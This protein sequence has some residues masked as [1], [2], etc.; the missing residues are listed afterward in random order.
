[1]R[2][3]HVKH[4]DIAMAP[5]A[6]A[7]CQ[8][9]YGIKAAVNDYDM[10]YDIVHFHDKYSEVDFP[11]VIQYHSEPGY[12]V[13]LNVK[14]PKLVINQYHATLLNYYDCNIVQNIIDMDSDVFRDTKVGGIR[15]GY[16]PSS[17]SK[18]SE[19]AN[20]G[21]N[22]TLDI[23]DDVLRIRGDFS[24]DVITDV[25][26]SECLERKRKC[27]IIIDEV[28]TDSFHRSALEGLAGGKM[29]ICTTSTKVRD[30][31]RMSTGATRIPFENID[32][33]HLK[34]FLLSV[35]NEQALKI[36]EANRKWFEKYWHPYKIVRDFEKIYTEVINAYR[37]NRGSWH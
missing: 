34:N 7:E 37:N 31:V 11:S 6:L 5:D 14:I 1:M 35:T 9:K 25:S 15:V 20:K 21:Y 32:I 2:V 17:K 13:D 3:L 8:N 23:L 28:A 19:W 29:V 24:F 18:Q 30:V 4:T 12:R 27:N 26:L 10:D 16:S 33:L 36:G 22:E